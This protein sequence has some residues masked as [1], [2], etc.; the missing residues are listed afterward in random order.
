MKKKSRKSIVKRLDTVFSLYIR[1][2]DAD[3]NGYVKCISCDKIKH[4]KEVDAG[5]FISRRYMS[6]RY[7]VLNVFAQCRYC[8]R[9]A[10]GNQWLYSKALE[11][12]KKGLPKKLYLKSKQTKKYSGDD[13]ES[14][15]T[16]YNNLLKKLN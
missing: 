12:I 4:Y 5:H 16:F 15:I 7:D 3:Q 6:T 11:K 2:K 10:E 13:L 1:L 8:N 14:L 9:Y